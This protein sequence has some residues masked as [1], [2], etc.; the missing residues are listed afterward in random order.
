LPDPAVHLTAVIPG[1]AKRRPTPSPEMT[2]PY[3]AIFDI[4]DAE[5]SQ[6]SEKRSQTRSERALRR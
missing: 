1:R 5:R 6:A 2:D 4:L 3:L